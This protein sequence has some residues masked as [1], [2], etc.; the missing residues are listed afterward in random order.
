MA[1][2]TALTIVVPLLQDMLFLIGRPRHRFKVAT[3]MFWMGWIRPIHFYHGVYFT[4]ALLFRIYWHVSAMSTPGDV[5]APA[6]RRAWRKGRYQRNPLKRIFPSS[7]R[8][9]SL[10]CGHNPVA[11]WRYVLISDVRTMV[12]SG[13]APRRRAWNRQATYQWFGWMIRLT[14]NDSPRYI[15]GTGWA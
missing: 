1:P 5:S 12:C 9:P 15:S 6:W 3:F 2:I 7:K 13:F 4:V 10:L 8:G 14:G 11:D